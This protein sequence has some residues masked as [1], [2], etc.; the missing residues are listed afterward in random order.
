R[1]V[2]TRVCEVEA[3]TARPQLGPVAYAANLRFQGTPAVALVFTS[4]AGPPST[5]LV[6]APQEGCRILAESPLS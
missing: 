2:G 5:L 3:R 6:L 4:A 1:Q